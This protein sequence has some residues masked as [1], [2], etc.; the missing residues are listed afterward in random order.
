M[1]MLRNI[2]LGACA[3]AIAAALA[4][5]SSTANPNSADDVYE[6]AYSGR[7]ADLAA[8]KVEYNADL[9]EL[10]RLLDTASAYEDELTAMEPVDQYSEWEVSSYNSLV[11]RYNRVADE[12]R[13]AAHS[14]NDKY[15]AFAEG[16]DGTVSTSPDNISLPDPIP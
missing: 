4:A 12:Y 16:A 5:C 6:S 9:A 8:V 10:R 14:F 7:S 1:T 15:K 3:V 2:A 11:N 13:F